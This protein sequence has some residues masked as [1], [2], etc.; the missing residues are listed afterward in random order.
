MQIRLFEIKMGVQ[1]VPL[2]WLTVLFQVPFR[3]PELKKILESFRSL[4]SG[5]GPLFLTALDTLSDFLAACGPV[6][7]YPVSFYHIYNINLI[8]IF[9]GVIFLF[10]L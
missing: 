10:Q 1:F 3:T 8:F 9:S 4:L 2:I 5:R 7:D 6:L